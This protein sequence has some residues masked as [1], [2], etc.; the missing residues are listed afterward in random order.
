[1]SNHSLRPNCQPLQ[2]KYLQYFHCFVKIVLL[3]QPDIC[4]PSCYDYSSA[5]IGSLSERKA[6]AAASRAASGR[7]L[8]T[9]VRP[10]SSASSSA[11]VGASASK[12]HS[13]PAPPL[14][15]A[16]AGLST[17]AAATTS[18]SDSTTADGSAF[19]AA[20]SSADASHQSHQSHQSLEARLNARAAL[21]RQSA[22]AEAEAEAEL[23]PDADSTATG[24][25]GALKLMLNEAI[26]Q[27]F[28][29]REIS[30]QLRRM[31]RQ[32][33]ELEKEIQASLLESQRLRERREATQTQIELSLAPASSGGSDTSVD[34]QSQSQSQSQRSAMG[35]LSPIREEVAS[36]AGASFMSPSA[37]AL[38]RYSVK[39]SQSSAS[40]NCSS[41]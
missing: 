15:L 26:Q 20:L 10:S 31:T 37:S 38:L 23:E 34:D 4:T 40:T 32:E 21:R 17:A 9:P 27:K 19:A 33:V 6:S 25:F 14:S 11:A 24:S 41:W 16:S 7:P 28:E 36:S 5:H 22:D 2:M 13:P 12:R 3:N 35:M 1:M 8:S 39:C 30:Q 29:R 18:S